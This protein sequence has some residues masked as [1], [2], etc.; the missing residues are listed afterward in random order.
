MKTP[1]ERITKFAHGMELS[2]SRGQ[3]PVEKLF[4]MERCNYGD[5]LEVKLPFVNDEFI[6]QQHLIYLLKVEVMVLAGKPDYVQKWGWE[7]GEYSKGVVLFYHQDH[8]EMLKGAAEWLEA[9][10]DPI[11]PPYEYKRFGSTL[12]TPVKCE[13]IG[14]IKHYTTTEG[15]EEGNLERK[16]SW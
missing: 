15:F 12:I 13:P 5:T 16:R 2:I 3:C 9:R 6:G 1:I 14:R 4:M 7:P 10:I 11:A 8:E